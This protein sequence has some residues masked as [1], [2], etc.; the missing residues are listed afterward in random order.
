MNFKILI[1]CLT[2]LFCSTINQ[3]SNVDTSSLMYRSTK[4]PPSVKTPEIAFDIQSFLPWRE[5]KS[6][7]GKF[8]V[9][10]PEGEM[11][12]KI[13]KIKTDLGDIPFHT[14]LNRPKDKSTDNMFYLVNYCDYPK[15]TFPADSMDLINEFL[16]TTIEQSAHSVGGMITYS[17]DIEQRGSKGKIW[18][19]QYN[20]DKA[21][22][23]SKCYIV[24]DRFYMIQTM[25]LREKAVNPSADKFLDSFQFF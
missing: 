22:I 14:F 18:R 17:G 25:M 23:K 20:N 5:F 12:E 4:I 13:S 7:D 3:A 16:T 24:G 19:V 6:F 21:L 15:G 8:R 2:F 10:V 1:F 9:V 11:T